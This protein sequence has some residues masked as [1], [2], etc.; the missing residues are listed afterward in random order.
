MF[1]YQGVNTAVM[2]KM[3]GLS[4]LSEGAP[5]GL[6]VAGRLGVDDFSE[7]GYHLALLLRKTLIL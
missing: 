2:V 5:V 4:P 7:L 1:C 6:S 3:M